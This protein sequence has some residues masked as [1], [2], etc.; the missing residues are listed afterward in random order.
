MP[1][2]EISNIMPLDRRTLQIGDKFLEVNLV[3]IPKKTYVLQIICDLFDT[4]KVIVPPLQQ[5]EVPIAYYHATLLQ[6][7]PGQEIPTWIISVFQ[8]F[9]HPRVR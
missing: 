1:P 2:H 5:K 4:C 8:F 3:W 7:V 9:A 6:L